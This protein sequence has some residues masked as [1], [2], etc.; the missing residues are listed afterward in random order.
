[1]FHLFH[2]PLSGDGLIFW[3]SASLPQTSN[4]KLYISTDFFSFWPCQMLTHGAQ[5]KIVSC[6]KRAFH[7]TYQ[8]FSAAT[9]YAAI[10][11]PSAESNKDTVQYNT[12]WWPIS[13][14]YLLIWPL[15]L[16]Q[17]SLKILQK[18][19][20]RQ[21]RLCAPVLS[22]VLKGNSHKRAPPPLELQA[23]VWGMWGRVEFA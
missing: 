18:W 17:M 3:N 21:D 22:E 7:R 12:T 15:R 11:R 10:L 9:L 4:L 5:K 2:A 19:Y 13:Q 16:L 1:M 14:Y 6:G 20:F 8:G 23:T